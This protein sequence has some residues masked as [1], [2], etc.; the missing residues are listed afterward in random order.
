MDKQVI[1]DILDK[2]LNEYT[3][4][5][6]HDELDEAI[7]YHNEISRWLNELKELDDKSA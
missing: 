7:R 3:Y 4:L 1:N 6:Q 2:L 5:I